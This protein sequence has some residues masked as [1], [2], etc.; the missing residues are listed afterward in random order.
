MKKTA[1]F[2][3]LSLLAL[4][5]VAMA[6]MIGDNPTV[7]IGRG[8]FGQRYWFVAA[9]QDENRRG[10]C[11]ETGAFERSPGV[12]GEGQCSAPAVKR[13][14]LE[15]RFV[16]DAAADTDVMTAIGGAFNVAVKAVEVTLFDGK[17]E[18]LTPKRVTSSKARRSTVGHFRYLAFA[19]RGPWCA[20]RLVTIGADGRP[21]WETG[22]EEFGGYARPHD[23]RSA[24]RG[25]P[26][27]AS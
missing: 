27:R 7:L 20:E 6:S 26:G 13:G 19:V 17:T 18:R 15:A 10:I 8:H 12:D 4:C 22:W 3:S 25:F 14:I 9:A 5:P 24:C 11:F 21:L 2:L 1:A 23:P 16:P